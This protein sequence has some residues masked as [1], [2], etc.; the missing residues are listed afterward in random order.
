MAGA[1]VTSGGEGVCFGFRIQSDT[2]FQFL[3]QG[4]ADDTLRVCETQEPL[5]APDED[6]VAEWVLR[7]TG[8]DVTARLFHRDGVFHSWTNDGGWFRI[9]PAAR[10]IEMTRCAD[11]VRREQR[12]WGIPAVTCFM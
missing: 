6:L 3:R 2:P 4:H 7:E 1:G 5:C 8:R 11:L 10:R 12:L 9:D